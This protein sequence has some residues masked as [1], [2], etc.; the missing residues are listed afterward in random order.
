[1]IISTCFRCPKLAAIL[2]LI[3]HI[4]KDINYHDYDICNPPGSKILAVLQLNF[5]ILNWVILNS[6]QSLNS[7][8]FLFDTVCILLY[9]ICPF[10]LASCISQVFWH[11]SRFLEEGFDDILPQKILK[12]QVFGNAI[13]HSK[14]KSACF[15]PLHP[16][17]VF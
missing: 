7:N 8:Y 13:C 4:N 10:L 5:A 3:Q 16:K 14:A 6:S 1:M 2:N 9:T 12:F 15:N 17:S 11:L